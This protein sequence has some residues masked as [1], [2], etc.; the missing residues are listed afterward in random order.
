MVLAANASGATTVAELLADLTAAKR[1]LDESRPTAVN[2]MWATARLLALASAIAEHHGDRMDVAAVRAKLLEEA[3]TLCEDDVALN[4]RIGLHGAAVVPDGA[5]ILHHCNTG[6]LATV[7]YGT[8]IGII[9]SCHAL[10][11]NVHVWVDETRPRL[12]GAKLTAWELMKA[13]VPMHLIPDNAAG[14]LM[15]QG[16]VD[17]VLFGAD[18]VTANGDVANKVGTMKVAVC[19][20]EFGVPV[21]AVVPTSTIDLTLES[22]RLIPI[23]ERSA[24]EVTHVGDSCVAPVGCP[25]YNPG[26][27][28]TPFKF[29]T[30]IITEEGICY[31]PFTQS[32][33]KAKEA[34]EARIT[35]SWQQRLSKLSA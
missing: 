23:E 30:G 16:K 9:Y 19:A 10:G 11:K 27:D 3:H 33:K 20:K 18:R 26:F 1:V 32:L 14:L 12:Q 34:A 21:Y 17:V 6:T 35:A 24:T 5:N 31:P 29:L 28:V 13:G 15:Y 7:Q 2:L 22:G 4:K 8:A 25:V